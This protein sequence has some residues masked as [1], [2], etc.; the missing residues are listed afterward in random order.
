MN[1]PNGWSK[2]HEASTLHRKL[3]AAK[4][5]WQW[6]GGPSQGRA[7]QLIVQ[8]QEVITENRH[9]VNCVWAQQVVFRNIYLYTSMHTIA[10]NEKRGRI[11]LKGMVRGWREGFGGKK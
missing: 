1:M 2:A 5:S 4:Q 6:G 11:D 7:H 10:M 9:I 3:E 8:C